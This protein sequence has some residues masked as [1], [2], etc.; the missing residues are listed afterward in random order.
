MLYAVKYLNENREI[1]V[2]EDVFQ[3]VFAKYI[4]FTLLKMDH[5]SSVVLK[6]DTGGIIV[7]RKV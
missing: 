3:D 6:D 1:T 4:D 2:S 5:I 7:I